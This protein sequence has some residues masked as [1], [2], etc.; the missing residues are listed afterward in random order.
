MC[1]ILACYSKS[2]IGGAMYDTLSDCLKQI[3]HRGALNFKQ[4]LWL[5]HAFLG[6]HR[7]VSLPY[8][9]P[10]LNTDI[11]MVCDAELY[12][13]DTLIKVHQ[14][15]TSTAKPSPNSVIS[16]MYAIQKRTGDMLCDLHTCVK[17]IL[18]EIDG[19]FAGML[20]D[21]ETHT[22]HAFRDQYGVRPLFYGFDSCDRVYFGSEAKALTDIC[23]FI[24]QV[25]PGRVMSITTNTETGIMRTQYGSYCVDAACLPPTSSSLP[26][27][28]FTQNLKMLM[29]DAIRKRCTA[30]TPTA[31]C[32]LLSGGL[33]SSLIASVIAQ[34]EKAHGRKLHTFAIGMEGSRDLEYAHQV[35]THIGSEH[36]DIICTE[37]DLIAAIPHAIKAIE[38]FDVYNVRNATITYLACKYIA[39]RTQF[40]NIITGD[41]ADDV[42]SGH[43]YMNQAPTPNLFH[44]ETLTL[45][46]DAHYFSLLSTERIAAALG[47]QA[48]MPFADKAFVEFYLRIPV[49]MR[50]PKNN[51]NIEKFLIRLSF[52]S[53]L[54]PQ[55]LWRKKEQMSDGISP[56]KDKGTKAW[57]TIIKK[58]CAQH[59]PG[60]E[61]QISQVTKEGAYYLRLFEQSYPRYPSLGNI[62]PYMWLPKWHGDINDPSARELP[63]S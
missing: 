13:I 53:S 46:K 63:I 31:S 35:A 15:E 8:S 10:T 50:M 49:H 23:C 45:V 32:V 41:F 27:D 28:F 6:A 34:D 3:E 1:G 37:S 54:P 38:S 29:V 30:H 22:I 56:Q 21:Q 62:I 18:N 24:D 33:N 20:Y 60:R 2:E 58:H 48:V 14:L 57:H 11:F 25:K 43:I 19:D 39:E 17:N 42:M 12:N 52:A 26:I 36:T 55:I 7:R 44:D 47:L 4:R 61:P 9:I 51:H 59:V 5:K 40:A 16:D